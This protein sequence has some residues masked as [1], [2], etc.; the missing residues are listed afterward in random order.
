MRR[1]STLWV[2]AASILILAS[3]GEASTSSEANSSVVG[4]SQTTSTSASITTSTPASSTTSSST[5]EVSV[6]LS[7][8]AEVEVGKTIALTAAVAGATNQSVT[9]TSS[10]AAIATVSNGV[11]TGVSA[12]AVTIRATSVADSSKYAEKSI[13]V[14]EAT[15]FKATIALTNIGD[16]SAVAS[17]KEGS[18]AYLLT[19]TP[20][21][22][23]AGK[24]LDDC[25][26]TFPG[27]SALGYFQALTTPVAN[28]RNFL[29]NFA[30]VNDIKV[31]VACGDSTATA[32][33]KLIIAKDETLY[34]KI[35][36]PDDF[37]SKVLAATTG[38]FELAAN[39]DLDGISTNGAKNNV[40][41]NGEL[42]GNGYTVKNFVAN[43]INDG[44]LGGLWAHVGSGLIRNLHLT[45]TENQTAG[46][47]S[48]LGKEVQDMAI[49][50]DCLF[51]AT[52]IVDTSA[53]FDWT[54]KRS[55]I[56]AGSL[57]GTIRNCV[58]VNQTAN[59]QMLDVAPYASG[60]SAKIDN[61]YTAQ[62]DEALI[63]PFDPNGGTQAWS[64]TAT[65]TNLH[66][67]MVWANSKVAD[68]ALDNTIWALADGKM[69]TLAHDADTFVKA[70]PTLSAAATSASLTVGG[71]SASITAS[72]NHFAGA[73]TYSFEGSSGY[74]DVISVT[75]D[76]T[77]ATKFAVAPVAPGTASVTIKA[78][79]G[80]DTLSATPIEFTV[81]PAGAA[82]IYTIPE[83]A[84]EIATKD[85]F[86]AYFDGSAAN[87]TKNAY[88]SAD[89]NLAGTVISDIKMA[90]EYTA[91]FEGQGHR[92]SNF[93]GSRPFFNIIG[94]AGQVR[95][96]A[97]VCDDFTGSGFGTIAYMNSGKM[98]NVDVT[99]I[100]NS[101]SINN[102]G[103]CAFVGTGTFIDCDSTITVNA[104]SNT[105]FAIARADAGSTFT[106]C[107]YFV[108]GTD[109]TAATAVSAS[110]A[111]GVTLRAS[112]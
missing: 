32:E 25:T 14:K 12:G 22:F 95:N 3:C 112:K 88:L 48:L 82:P 94:A 20:E 42:D 56:F 28:Q 107:T 27:D 19:V 55:G 35:A 79:D 39:L 26:F 105:L 97:F 101:T 13:T 16:G 93:T 53:N 84:T 83:N 102:W 62:S 103:P 66:K 1:N 9:W 91:I 8:E 11:V 86:L 87:T 85:A 36:T 78:T 106:N 31:A 57:K 33:L 47:G 74:A 98:T 77:D 52:S 40:T 100:I 71:A 29:A 5:E 73:V 46:W 104:G 68:Y 80:T 63:I 41:F 34:T 69:P 4:S 50:E 89:I 15:A 92:V 67:G 7:G 99:A 60:A 30:G 61:V 59:A 64:G 75:Q 51:E 45:G 70:S 72:A 6:T 90:G 110:A 111:S 96:V 23:P 18:G 65:V 17:L 24:T 49:V 58:T 54:W 76:S 2:L 37:V 21:N 81:V 38:H 44:T 109:G 108:D 43:P 10:N